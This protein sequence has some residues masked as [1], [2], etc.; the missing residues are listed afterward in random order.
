MSKG[1]SEKRAKPLRVGFS[2][3]R[4]VGEAG[5]GVSPSIDPSDDFFRIVRKRMIEEHLVARGIRDPRVLAAMEKIPRHVF[6]EEALRDQAYQD[7]PLPIGEGQTISQPYIVALMDQVLELKG[8]ERVLEIGAGCGYQTAV[9]ATLAREVYAI[10][11]IKSLAL[12]AIA[13][14]KRLGVRNVSIRVGDGT[15]GWPEQ[16]PFDAI[17]VAAATPSIPA[18]F[19][20]QL[21]EGGRL[22]IPM[23][24]EGEQRLLLLQRVGGAWKALSET[25]CRFVPLIGAHGWTA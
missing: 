19:L 5:G 18:P 1:T 12:K 6:V 3:R 13:R 8:D 15:L 11:R 4:R 23:E 7:R 20:A 21:K 14:L 9:L 10:E 2:R 16:A 22:V 24:R 25:P 17:T